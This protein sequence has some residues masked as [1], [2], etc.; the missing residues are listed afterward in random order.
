MSGTSRRSLVAEVSAGSAPPDT[1]PSA[2][3]H[4]RQRQAEA[5]E[6]VKAR[7]S[8]RPRAPKLD[9]STGAARI[10]L[11]SAHADDLD[12]FSWQLM[13][14]LGT[15]DQSLL[16]AM[17][18][19]LAECAGGRSA[20]AKVEMIRA[21]LGF[22]ADIAPQNAVE[23]ALG[24]QMFA[25]HC[26]TMEMSRLLRTISDPEGV[27]DLGS[28]LNKT[29]R[30][31]AAQAEALA[32]L[33]TGGKQQVE[34]RYVYVDARNSQNVIGDVHAKAGGV[35]GN[36]DQPH[37][38]A[39]IAGPPAS[40]GWPLCGEDAAGRELPTARNAQQEPLPPARRKK[41]RCP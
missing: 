12:G 40:P 15:G 36:H 41:P 6:R 22:L 38:P 13:D 20:E 21:A 7:E 4:I 14:V 1:R 39:A 2:P 37:V 17:V 23:G 3:E 8:G 9:E 16:T 29:A 31:F 32:K 11:R 34:V 27:R 35:L 18:G 24:T 10:E 5:R 28:L 19:Q 30:T 26:A 33:R 25:V